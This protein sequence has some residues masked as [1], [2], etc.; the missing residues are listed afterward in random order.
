MFS[1]Q[2]RV[3]YE[4][5]ACEWI[6]S[7]PDQWTYTKQGPV[8]ENSIYQGEFYDAREELQGWNMPGLSLIH[9]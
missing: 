5:G 2:L 9:I 6:H 1:L 8:H 4:D 7:N 3:E